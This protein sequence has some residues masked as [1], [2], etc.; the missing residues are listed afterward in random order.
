[1]KAPVIECRCACGVDKATKKDVARVNRLTGGFH[2]L[3]AHARPTT[4]GSYED[5]VVISGSVDNE[6]GAADVVIGERI[7]FQTKSNCA[8]GGAVEK[9]LRRVEGSQLMAI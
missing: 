9:V 1:V 6:R 8:R 7:H 2:V 3:A 5:M 4:V